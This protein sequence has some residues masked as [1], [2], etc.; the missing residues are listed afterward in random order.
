MAAN[1]HLVKAPPAGHG[2]VLFY[3]GPCGDEECGHV[4]VEVLRPLDKGEGADGTKTDFWKKFK[5]NIKNKSSAGKD[6]AWRSI[7][8]VFSAG[9]AKLASIHYLFFWCR[10]LVLVCSPGR[11]HSKISSSPL[12]PSCRVCPLSHPDREGLKQ[13]TI[14]AAVVICMS[15]GHSAMFL[16]PLPR[17]ELGWAGAWVPSRKQ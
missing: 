16:G 11:K 12:S 9:S 4:L 2:S 6:P 14:L 10:L 5:T 1:R 8:G 13:Q 7:N 15:P 3:N 17:G